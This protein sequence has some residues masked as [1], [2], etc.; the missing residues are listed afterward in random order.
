MAI[1]SGASAYRFLVPA[2]RCSISP[3]SLSTR[4]C[5]L[6]AGRPT[7]SLSA[8]R[9]TGVGPSRS[10]SR[11]RRRTGSPS[12]SNTASADWLLMSNGYSRVTKGGDARAPRRSG[13][14]RE[15]PHRSAPP[16]A[17]PVVRRFLVRQEVERGLDAPVARRH[18]VPEPLGR[19]GRADEQRNPLGSARRYPECHQHRMHP[20]GETAHHVAGG[21]VDDRPGDLPGGRDGEAS[22]RPVADQQPVA[23]LVPGANHSRPVEL[24]LGL[25]RSE[26]RS[27]LRTRPPRPPG[28]PA[29]RI[30]ERPDRQMHPVAELPVKTRGRLLRPGRQLDKVRR[31]A[32]VPVNA[33]V[34]PQRVR[35]F[36]KQPDQRLPELTPR[37][38]ATHA[39]PAPP[40]LPSRPNPP[41]PR[42]ARIRAAS[43]PSGRAAASW[44]RSLIVPLPLSSSGWRSVKP[45]SPPRCQPY[46]EIP[47]C[48]APT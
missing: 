45:P 38:H 11:I 43:S 44:G 30:G 5:L 35:L 20:A 21:Q 36:G 42:T 17:L 12:A 1:P 33:G 34:S 40:R 37:H 39:N 10:S 41:Q 26:Q 14:D 23:K 22:P 3:A 48:Q 18:G 13:G 19:A 31:R 47:C 16:D 4:R 6:T 27:R 15:R 2:L 29:R 24:G 28:R 25:V 7:G 9:P 32:L 8:S 46:N